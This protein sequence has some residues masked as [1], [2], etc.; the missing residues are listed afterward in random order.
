M[1]MPEVLGSP[2][3]SWAVLGS[4]GL[5]WAYVGS[6]GLCWALLDSPG[7]SWATGKDVARPIRIAHGGRAK[8]DS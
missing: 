4:P 6:P 1:G 5:S 7:L 2:G 8:K 3:L